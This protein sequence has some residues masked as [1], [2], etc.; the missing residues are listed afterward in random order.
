M[1]SKPA[2]IGLLGG[3][4]AFCLT[5][6]LGLIRQNGVGATL[7]RATIAALVLTGVL[8][9]SVSVALSVVRDGLRLYEEENMGEEE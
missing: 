4:M 1:S 3:I 5:S 6:M 2:R 9:V 7:T 8:W